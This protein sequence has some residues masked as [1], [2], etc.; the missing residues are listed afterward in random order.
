MT[1]PIPEP[2]PEPFAPVD[3]RASEFGGRPG[4]YPRT[5]DT[6]VDYGPLSADQALAL[7]HRGW[8]GETV[9][10]PEDAYEP[11][12]VEGLGAQRVQ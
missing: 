1:T 5:S 6:G 12:T 9:D 10:V 3:Q 8:R 11:Y 4:L 2:V 7:L